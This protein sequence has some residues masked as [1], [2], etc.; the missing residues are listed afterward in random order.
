[1]TLRYRFNQ[2]I[3]QKI[4]FIRIWISGMSVSLKDIYQ[5]MT[6]SMEIHLTLLLLI[7]LSRQFKHKQIDP[8]KIINQVV[9]TIET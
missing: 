4:M 2:L 6:L 5:I 1:M 3:Y 9:K 8:S 7:K